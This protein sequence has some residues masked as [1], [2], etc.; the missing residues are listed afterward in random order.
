MIRAGFIQDGVNL[1]QSFTPRGEG[2]ADSD[3][4]CH[5]FLLEVA[6]AHQRK[7][8]YRS[9]LEY[10]L[11]LYCYEGNAGKRPKDGRETSQTSKIDPVIGRKE[12]A[13]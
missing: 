4:P 11:Q 12:D 10:C 13:F 2:E 5:W 3:S 1:I 9:S 8:E 6:R 7:A